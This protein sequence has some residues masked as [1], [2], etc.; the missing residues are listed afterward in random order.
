MKYIRIL[1]TV[2]LG[3]IYIP[4]NRFHMMVQKWYFAQKKKDKITWYLFTPFYWIIVSITF[5]ISIPYDF[6]IAKNL[7]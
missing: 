1:L 4:I 6:L 3:I 7:H 5:I 2:I